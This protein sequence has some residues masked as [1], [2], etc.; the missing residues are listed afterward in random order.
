MHSLPLVT[1]CLRSDTDCSQVTE[2]SY[3]L[4]WVLA[5]TASFTCTTVIAGQCR[6]RKQTIMGKY[7]ARHAAF[8]GGALDGHAL[9]TVSNAV[10]Y[11]IPTFA[12][13]RVSAGQ[14][15]RYVLDTGGERNGVYISGKRRN[16][17]PLLLGG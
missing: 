4:T 7:Q 9:P 16:A 13:D 5:V 10:G 1:H 12:N 15:M 6:Q 17:A 2:T 8:T 11:R 3:I 14:E